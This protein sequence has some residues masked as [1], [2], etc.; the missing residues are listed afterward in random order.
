MSFRV[1][2]RHTARSGED[3]MVHVDTVVVVF[4]LFFVVV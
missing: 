1:V 4:V 3:G 2:T